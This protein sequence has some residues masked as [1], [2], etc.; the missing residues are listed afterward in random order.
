MGVPHN[1][2]PWDK[3]VVC[4]NQLT[5]LMPIQVVHQTQ[6]IASVTIG[7]YE[8]YVSIVARSNGGGRQHEQASC[9]HVGKRSTIQSLERRAGGWR[10]YCVNDTFVSTSRSADS[11]R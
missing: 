2:R 6:V 7:M 4:A 1:L 10:F 11:T 8:A 5:F 3:R 9:M